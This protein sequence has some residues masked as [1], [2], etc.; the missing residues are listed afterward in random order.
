MSDSSLDYIYTKKF[1]WPYY[2]TIDEMV[3][4]HKSTCKEGT[5][6]DSCRYIVFHC[7]DKLLDILKSP[8]NKPSK[9]DITIITFMNN[10]EWDYRPH[11]KVYENRK[12]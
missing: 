3:E 1:S 7:Y 10:S 12:V 2:K 5:I 8:D 6:E 9:H 11:L 4:H